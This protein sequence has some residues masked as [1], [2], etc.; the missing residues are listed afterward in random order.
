MPDMEIVKRELRQCPCCM[1]IHEVCTAIVPTTTIFKNQEVRY[2]SICEY[3]ESAEE[4]Y[5]TEGEISVND[6]AMK[7]AYRKQNSL[8]TSQEIKQIREKYS[9]SQEAFAKAL[10]WGAKTITRYEGHQVQDKAHDLVLRH[11]DEDPNWF[12]QI[13]NQAPP[14]R[15][16]EI[17]Q[18][19]SS[20]NIPLLRQALGVTQQTFS[21]AIGVSCDTVKAWESGV[22]SPTSMALKM[23]RLIQED[24]TLFKK[25]QL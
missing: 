9:M 3:C 24:H 23:L 10:G 4:L 12:L 17:S 19:C 7:D 11:I 2:F 14:L 1:E 20:I 8:L 5:E 22:L 16:P 18:S 15:V 13:S 6:A 25:L 21:D